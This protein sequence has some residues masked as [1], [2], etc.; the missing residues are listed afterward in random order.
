MLISVALQTVFS[1]TLCRQHQWTVSI[2]DKI[3][4][5]II[6][7]QQ[8][9]FVELQRDCIA[10]DTLPDGVITGY[11]DLPN[12]LAEAE[13]K[14]AFQQLSTE[15]VIQNGEVVQLIRHWTP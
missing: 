9:F 7:V 5:L 4:V 2:D 14:G 12:S 13:A 1:Y 10:E 8:F 3:T 15:A 11:A 6:S